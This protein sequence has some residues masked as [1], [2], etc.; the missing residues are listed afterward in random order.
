M[1]IGLV[2]AARL[3]GSLGISDPRLAGR[4]ARLLGKL[5]LP[6]TAPPG[7]DREALLR[8]IG[9]DKKRRGGS[10]VFIVPAAG[11]C[12]A[13]EGIDPERALDALN[14]ETL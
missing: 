12:E 7:L 8:A 3:G 11:G 6:S 4:L 9:A 2:A 1:A 14:G 10:P 5:G 13:V